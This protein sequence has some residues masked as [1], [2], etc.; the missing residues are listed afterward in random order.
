ML[1]QQRMPVAQYRDAPKKRAMRK[2]R[3]APTEIDGLKFDSKAEAKRWLELCLLQKAGQISKLERQVRYVL[4]PPVVR[5]SGGRERECAYIADF[6]YFD[7]RGQFTVCEDVKGAV[8]P[9]FR[10]KRKL[11]LWVHGIEIREVKA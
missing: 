1:G 11:M 3:N 4:I 9:E 2:R 10:L 5:P 7:E 8:T 6:V